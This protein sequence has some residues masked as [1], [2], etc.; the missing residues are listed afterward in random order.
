[1]YKRK[2]FPILLV[3]VLLMN[4]LPARAEPLFYGLRNKM[5]LYGN[6]KDHYTGPAAA[7]TVLHYLCGRSFSQNDLADSTK[8]TAEGTYLQDILN[9][10]HSEQ[11][12]KRFELYN[13][14]DYETFVYSIYDTLVRRDSPVIVGIHPDGE[15]DWPNTITAKRYVVLYQ[16]SSDLK[17]VKMADPMAL[18]D[19]AAGGPFYELSADILYRAYIHARVGL[20]YGVDLPAATEDASSDRTIELTVHPQRT[21]LSNLAELRYSIVNKS[22]NGISFGLDYTLQKWNASLN[23]WQEIPFPETYVFAAV[24]LGILKPG[25]ARD[26][27]IPFLAS[28]QL[29]AGSY[30]ITKRVESG[31]QYVLLVSNSFELK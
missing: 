21:D 17:Q 9:T 8:T 22:T 31:E 11:N 30:R 10:I 3:L 26:Y 19:D 13:G 24:Y 29:E 18:S 2:I 25:E 4:A 28:L 1:M 23:K 7:K 12:L 14:Q 6:I 20:A 15:K 5:T 16:I 27:E